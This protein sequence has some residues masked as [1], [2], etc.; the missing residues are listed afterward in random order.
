M[1]EREAFGGRRGAAAGPGMRPR[2]GACAERR[3]GGGSDA[4]PVRCGKRRIHARARR[5]ARRRRLEGW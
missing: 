5:C 3:E 1:R 4:R 2:C